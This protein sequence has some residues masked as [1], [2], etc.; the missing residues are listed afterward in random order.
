M[1]SRLVLAVV[2]AVIVTL[3]CILVGSV[4]ADLSVQIAVTIGN[5]IKS[6]SSVIGIAAGIWYYFNG[7]FS[8]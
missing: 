7:S 3:A 1:I 4:L 6:W 8:L 2:V 5:V